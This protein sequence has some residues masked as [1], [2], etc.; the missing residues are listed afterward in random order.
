MAGERALTARLRRFFGDHPDLLVGIG[1]DAAVLRQRHRREVVCCDPVVAGVHF[2]ADAPLDLVGQKVVNRNLSDLAA[3][4]AVPDWL[5]LSLVLPPDLD[6]RGLDL[7]LRGVRRAA[8]RADAVVVG[9]DVA[10]TRGPLVATVTAIGHLEG[11]ALTRAGVRAG[12][13]LHVTGPLGGS[14]LG[15][16]LRFRPALV[17]GAWLARQRAVHAAIDV[18]DGLL[19]DLATMLAASGQ[20]GALGAELD[21]AAI[22]IRAA[23]R[24]L[25]AGDR[26]RALDAALRDGEDHV[27][28]WSQ[29]AQRELPAGG[30]L[31]ARARRPIGRVLDTPGIWLRDGDRRTRLAAVGFEHVV[32]PGRADAAR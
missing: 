14:R 6:A 28:L 5:L 2:D 25:H 31:G 9:G 4:G 29:A 12:D 13:T 15:H 23:A 18:S 7:L 24:R 32:P 3:M 19:L 17:E 10:S 27:L 8:R 16:H 21:A 30:P 22:P 26:R 20:H 1:D 11:R